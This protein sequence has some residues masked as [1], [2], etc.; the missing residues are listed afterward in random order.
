MWYSAKKHT[1]SLLLQ[2]LAKISR[3]IRG[4]Y[5]LVDN[6]QLHTKK[7]IFDSSPSSS[8]GENGLAKDGCGKSHLEQPKVQAH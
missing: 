5:H 8:S 7:K 1:S 4:S 6:H 2:S 3:K